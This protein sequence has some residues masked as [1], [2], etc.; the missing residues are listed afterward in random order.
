[1]FTT[2]VVYAAAAVDPPSGRTLLALVPLLLLVIGLMTYCLVDLAHAPSVRY[3]PK[4]VWALI[5]VLVSFPLGA[6]A[7]LVL[8]KDHHDRHEPPPQ[9]HGQPGRSWD[10]TR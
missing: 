2:A 7:Y 10:L 6:I 8:G 1:M 9:D 4:V 5:I 3:L